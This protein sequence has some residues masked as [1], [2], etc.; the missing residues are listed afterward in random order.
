MFWGNHKLRSIIS[1]PP[2]QKVLKQVLQVEEP[3]RNLPK[4]WKLVKM[5]NMKISMKYIFFLF[6][7]TLKDN[8]LMD[9]Q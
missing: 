4:K 2:L 9:K 5:V 1:S 3:E 7:T 8:C 6:L